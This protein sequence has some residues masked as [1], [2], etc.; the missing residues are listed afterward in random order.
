[1]PSPAYNQLS[2]NIFVPLLIKGLYQEKLSQGE[3]LKLVQIGANDGIKDD[4]LKNVVGKPGTSSLLVEPQPACV[5]KLKEKYVDNARVIIEERAIGAEAGRI[6]L[7][8][9]E[10]DVEDGKLISVFCSSDR[11]HLEKWK[12]RLGLASKIV[13]FGIDTIPLSE[14]IDQFSFSDIDILMTD[15]EGLDYE[16]LYP[17]LLN[18]SALPRWLIYE[19]CNLSPVQEE[20]MVSLVKK[21]GGEAYDFGMDALAVFKEI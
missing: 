5:T 18:C 11:Q 17:Y 12:E 10:S 14:L 2:S 16:I 21:L 7:F 6:K 4:P 15:V 19:K 3:V 20:L 13:S 1:M 9:F 8:K